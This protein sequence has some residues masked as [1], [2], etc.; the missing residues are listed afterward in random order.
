[1]SKNIQLLRAIKDA[2]F[3]TAAA[4][5]DTRVLD[6]NET[7]LALAAWRDYP[8]CMDRY[9]THIR[10]TRVVLDDVED[11]DKDNAAVVAA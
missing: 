6:D 3:P 4:H 10:H 11:K 7:D 1:M 9:P 2:G 8:T 5:L